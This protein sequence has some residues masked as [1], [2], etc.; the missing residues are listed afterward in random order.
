MDN[1]VRMKY[2]YYKKHY[3]DCNTVQ[4]SYDKGN[5]TI[6]VVVPADRL[7]PSGVRGQRF[8]SYQIYAIKQNGEKVFIVYK[9]VNKENA[10]KQHRKSCIELNYVYT[11]EIK[12]IF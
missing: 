4:N 2:S 3:A 12:A 11:E 9:A 7:K 1:V 5:K 6:D 8:K 10:L